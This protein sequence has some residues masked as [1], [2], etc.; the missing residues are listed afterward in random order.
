MEDALE[1]DISIDT[2]DQFGNTLLIL[3][4]QQGSRRMCKYL[5]R[6]GANINIQSLAGHTALRYCYAYSHFE[7]A[8]YL[9]SRGADDSILNGEGL[10]CYEGLS[11][12]G[13]AAIV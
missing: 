11:T 7:L 8:D 9:K 2:S 3:A 1:E 6:R 10:T 4:A 5:L 12:G 13:I